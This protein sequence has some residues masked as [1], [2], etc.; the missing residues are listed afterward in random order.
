[1]SNVCEHGSL[2]RKCE[3]CELEEE[4]KRLRDGIKSYLDSEIEIHELKGLIT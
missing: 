3:I 1:M 2:A 4:V